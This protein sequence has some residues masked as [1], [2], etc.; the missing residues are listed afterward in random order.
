MTLTHWSIRRTKARE[1][2]VAAIERATGLRGV[3]AV[4]DHALAT[5]LAQHDPEVRTMETKA[6]AIVA[7]VGG[8]VNECLAWLNDGD[9]DV[10]PLEECIEEWREV[11][12]TYQA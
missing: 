1:A 10:M 6:R 12:A 8:D 4:V 11:G 3:A 7:V 2:Q 9:G 5:T